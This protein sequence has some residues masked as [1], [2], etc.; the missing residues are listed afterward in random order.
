MQLIPM[1][2]YLE[3]QAVAAG[4]ALE[5]GIVDIAETDVTV[6]LHSSG[7]RESRS[8]KSD[9]DAFDHDGIPGTTAFPKP[10]PITRRG[11]VN[12]SNI[13]CACTSPGFNVLVRAE[14]TVGRL[15]RG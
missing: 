1:V 5:T 3:L 9:V 8:L 13:P 15:R 11:L 10:I 6:I 12:L 4:S 2:R 14:R 7:K